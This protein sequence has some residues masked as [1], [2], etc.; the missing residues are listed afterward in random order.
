MS[1]RGGVVRMGE[2][3]DG[4]NAGDCREKVKKENRQAS[5]SKVKF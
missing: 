3:G 1:E 4:G 2:M 5:G